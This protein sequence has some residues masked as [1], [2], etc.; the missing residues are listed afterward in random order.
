MKEKRP[1]FAARPFP[2]KS[3]FAY[4]HLAIDVSAAEMPFREKT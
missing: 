3:S 1:D 4:L 2:Q